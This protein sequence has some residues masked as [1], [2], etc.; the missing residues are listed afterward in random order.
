E[1]SAEENA[2]V[3]VGGASV[4]VPP[5]NVVGFGPFGG[6]FSSGPAASSV[7]RGEH[8][9]LGAVEDALRAA[10]AHGLLPGVVDD[11]FESVA[12]RVP[13]DGGERDGAL[14]TFDPASS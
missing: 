6:P 5:A 4:S 10:E 2:V 13:F 7:P 8:A 1:M 11:F 12:A 3:D 14:L 9:S